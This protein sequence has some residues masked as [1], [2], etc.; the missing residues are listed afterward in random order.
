MLRKGSDYPSTSERVVTEHLVRS[1]CK[2]QLGVSRG[3]PETRTARWPVQLS[4]GKGLGAPA[5]CGF[6][7]TLHQFGPEVGDEEEEQQ[8]HR[9]EDP[10]EQEPAGE[11]P[12]EH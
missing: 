11:L 6:P 2:S 4:P 12:Q 1:A 8:S 7:L 5:L 10:S 9:Q 3:P